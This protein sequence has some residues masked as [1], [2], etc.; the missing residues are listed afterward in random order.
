MYIEAIKFVM[1]L[2]DEH[3]NPHPKP[4]GSD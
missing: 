2:T 1:R 4:T 3:T